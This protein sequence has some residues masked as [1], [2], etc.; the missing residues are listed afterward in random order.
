MPSNTLQP[1][2]LPPYEILDLTLDNIIISELYK[3]TMKLLSTTKRIIIVT[4]AGIS[5]AAGIP[6]FRSSGGLF[7]TLKAD[8]KFKPSGKALFD[9]SVYKAHPT[10]SKLMCRVKREFN[11]IIK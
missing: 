6:D 9:V 7:S 1:Q 10:S 8:T 2:Y 5:V 3:T 4:G 11:R